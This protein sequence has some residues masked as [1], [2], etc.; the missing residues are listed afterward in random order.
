MSNYDCALIQQLSRVHLDQRISQRISILHLSDDVLGI[1]FALLVEIDTPL[2]GRRPTAHHAGWITVSWVCH[3]FRVILLAQHATFAQLYTQFPGAQ[4]EF[5]VILGSLEDL[6]ISVQ[7]QQ[8]DAGAFMRSARF[9]SCWLPIQAFGLEVFSLRWDDLAN[10]PRPAAFAVGMAVLAPHARSLVELE[11]C[12]ALASPPSPRDHLAL[13]SAANFPD[14]RLPRLRTLVLSGCVLSYIRLL[15]AL[16]VPAAISITVT[17]DCRKLENR[18]PSVSAA[19]HAILQRLPTAHDTVNTVAIRVQDLEDDTLEVV[20]SGWT[21]DPDERPARPLEDTPPLVRVSLVGLDP[22]NLD[23]ETYF[24][25][26][27][28]RIGRGGVFAAQHVG[29]IKLTRRENSRTFTMANVIYAALDTRSADWTDYTDASSAYLPATVSAR[30]NSLQGDDAHL[31]AY[32]Q[33]RSTPEKPILDEGVEKAVRPSLPEMG[34][35]D[36]AECHWVLDPW[37]LS[38]DDQAVLSSHLGLGDISGVVQG[39]H[40]RVQLDTS[41]PWLFLRSVDCLAWY[42]YAEHLKNACIIF[43]YPSPASSYKSA[44]GFWW[45]ESSLSQRPASRAA[46][47]ES[48]AI[49]RTEGHNIRMWK[50]KKMLAIAKQ[51]LHA[52]RFHLTQ[53]RRNAVRARVDLVRDMFEAHRGIIDVGLA[54]MAQFTREK[55]DPERALQEASRDEHREIHC[56]AGFSIARTRP[57]VFEQPTMAASAQELPPPDLRF[58]LAPDTWDTWA[59]AID[60]AL[61]ID[62]DIQ[63][64]FALRHLARVDTPPGHADDAALQNHVP[65]CGQAPSPRIELALVNMDWHIPAAVRAPKTND[66]IISAIEKVSRPLVRRPS[67]YLVA[68]A[69]AWTCPHAACNHTIELTRLTPAQVS[70][71]SQVFVGANVRLTETGFGRTAAIPALARE[72]VDMIA[73]AHYRSE[74]LHELAIRY[75]LHGQRD[76]GRSNK[77]AY[78]WEPAEWKH[79][80]LDCGVHGDTARRCE[81]A[82]RLAMQNALAAEARAWASRMLLDVQFEERASRVAQRQQQSKLVRREYSRLVYLKR[83]DSIFT[84]C[85]GSK[86]Y[87]KQVEAIQ[88]VHARYWDSD[89]LDLLVVGENTRVS[90][91]REAEEEIEFWKSG[92]ATILYMIVSYA[93][94]G[95]DVGDRT[96]SPALRAGFGPYGHWLYYTE[97]SAAMDWAVYLRDLCLSRR[98]DIQPVAPHPHGSRSRDP[99]Q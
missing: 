3:R 43:W 39:R 46:W 70:I 26:F 59:Q 67:D 57:P 11:L 44:P 95:P 32:L 48:Q 75:V 42:H 45:D 40:G 28:A 27:M 7:H 50:A 17:F 51:G 2:L 78:Y 61:G 58:S 74:H 9:T 63:A 41:N 12:D 1:I 72:V 89:L 31:P 15:G 80:F 91:R 47:L 62:Q 90:R 85:A 77:V 79:S 53:L 5:K 29:F 97:R 84:P 83:A 24:S 88:H 35:L 19:V 52:S 20:F 94:L 6:R 81:E 25:P 49:D 69:T 55:N 10:T 71:V 16:R 22:G 99:I 76:D 13:L 36:C 82:R 64:E 65:G 87:P 73:L 86:S 21:C 34:V 54:L 98:H 68:S 4:S 30:S 8:Q 18:A 14:L 33:V 37:N 66:A 92:E 93:M 96:G 60:D 23:W 38:V 56:T